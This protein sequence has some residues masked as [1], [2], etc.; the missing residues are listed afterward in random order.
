MD[1]EKDAERKHAHTFVE[2]YYQRWRQNTG[3]SV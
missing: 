1:E 2:S 3:L